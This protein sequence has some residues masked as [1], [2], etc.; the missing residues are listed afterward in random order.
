MLKSVEEQF[1]HAGDV[2]LPLLAWFAGP[3]IA[4]WCARICPFMS[5]DKLAAVLEDVS[6][7]LE[8]WVLFT[9]GASLGFR[10]AF[11]ADIVVLV[12][13]PDQL[14]VL[15]SRG[16]PARNVNSLSSG[17]LDGRSTAYKSLL[18][19]WMRFWISVCFDSSF[20]LNSSAN[21]RFSALSFSL[22]LFCQ[23]TQPDKCLE[24][25]FE[26]QSLESLEGRW[27]TKDTHLL[28]WDD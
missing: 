9:R 19:V 11:G 5:C 14:A 24:C 15:F 20:C 17:G 23:A 3:G 13:L 25:T 28:A 10:S 16:V 8:K 21:W 1:L 26:T 12:G 22:N 4:L 2:L 27:Q 18:L 6:A 7:S